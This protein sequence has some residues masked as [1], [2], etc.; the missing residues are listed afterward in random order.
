MKTTRSIL[1]ILTVVLF[2]NCSG[3]GEA[4]HTGSRRD[5]NLKAVLWYQHAAEMPALCYQAFNIARLRLDEALSGTSLSKPPAVVVDIDET[6]LDN[7]SYETKQILKGSSAKGWYNWTDSAAAIPL[8]GA[9][10]FARYAK[11]KGVEI[12][13][14]TNR[15]KNERASTLKNLN[16]AGFP[17]ATDEHLLTR[18]DTAFATGN[19]S[20]KAA[21][22]ATVAS[23]HEIIL[24]LGD[25]LNDFSEV[26]EDRKV[27]DGRQAVDQNRELFG[28]KYIVL[29]NPMYGAWEK[30]LTDYRKG[31]SKR[32]QTKLMRTK[33]IR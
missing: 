20:S 8:P 17:F 15:D 23:T 10:D 21:R 6:L 33:L 14:I 19:T 32:K 12:F 4:T 9:L 5:N 31:L 30:P 18:S 2:Y 1:L 3:P 16:A 11:S 7:S 22:R 26:F 29:P 28:K 13:Y 27:K 24:L 25:N